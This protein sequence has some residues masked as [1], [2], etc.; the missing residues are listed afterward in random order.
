MELG[1]I[2]LLAKAGYIVIAADG[3]GIPVIRNDQ[4]DLEGAEAVID[5]D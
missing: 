1:V 2:R 3:G 4:G 5:K